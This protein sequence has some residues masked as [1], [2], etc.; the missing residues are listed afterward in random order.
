[1]NPELTPAKIAER[2]LRGLNR[3]DRELAQRAETIEKAA[4][5]GGGVIGAIVAGRTHG[6]ASLGPVPAPFV[7]GGLAFVADFFGIGGDGPVVTAIKEAGYAGA[8]VELGIQQAISAQ[9]VAK[10]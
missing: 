6:M 7:A 9:R 1:M 3:E 4:E 5:I 8:L 10:I 2:G